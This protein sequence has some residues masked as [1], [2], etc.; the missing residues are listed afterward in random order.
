MERRVL[1]AEHF[2]LPIV[3]TE[4]DGIRRVNEPVT[5]GI[6]LSKGQLFNPAE[7]ALYNASN[8]RMPL[9][10]E[11]L[12]RWSDGSVQWV[13]LDF[14]ATVAPK[15]TVAYMLK[16]CIELASV[17][18]GAPIT[19]QE[20]STCITV[21]TGYALFFLNPMVCSPFERVIIQG[22]NVLDE[23]G[24]SIVLLDEEGRA[25]Q[26]CI[27]SYE[28]EIA[29]PLRTTLCLQG[30]FPGAAQ[31]SLA[32]FIARLS[33]YAG[34]G[35][36]EMRFTVHNP[37]AATHPDGLW[38]LGDTG[39]VYFRD[40]AF[41]LP[42]RA[43]N[44]VICMWTPQPPQPLVTSPETPLEIYQDSSGGQNWR[45]I[46]HTNR[47]GQVM[48]TFQGY[49]VT[50]DGNIIE[51]GKRATPI[52]ALGGH[53]TRVMAAVDKFWQ[54]FPKAMEADHNTLSIRLFPQQYRDVYELQG[55]E[56]KTH[57]V[58]LQFDRQHQ[59]I[60]DVSW[61][62]CRLQARTTPEWYVRSKA[63][64]YLTPRN[65][66][67]HADYQA[68]IDTAIEGNN[69]FFDRREIIDEYG[70][71][72]FGDLYADHEAVGHKGEAPLISHY[73]N[74][75]DVIYGA[76]IQYLR[77]GDVRWFHLMND[78][79]KHV[80]DI[81]IYHTSDDRPSYNGGMF[82]HTDH[83]VDA[84]TATHRTYSKANGAIN[85]GHLY[86]GGPSNEHNYTSGLLYYY[87]LTGEPLAREAV[88]S[89]AD[90]VINMD[91]GTRRLLGLFDR[92]PTGLA[93]STTNR[94]YHGPGRG[95]GNSINALLDAYLLTGY[96][97]YLSKAEELIRR[98]IHP[99]DEITKRELHDVEHRWSYT[100]FLQILGKYLDF[101][102]DRGE[103]DFMYGYA[104]ES[105][106]HY[107]RWMLEHEVP[108]TSILDRVEIPTE[109][110]PA[111]DIRKSNIFEFAA[112]HSDEP[113]RT[114]FF[115]KADVFFQ[116]CIR[117]LQSFETCT[118]TR[119][120]VL[121]M[122][123][124]FRHAYWQMHLDEWAPSPDKTYDFGEP[125]EFTPQL[126]GLYRAK[127]RFSEVMQTAK[128]GGRHLTRLLRTSL[129]RTAKIHG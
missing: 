26:P 113:L 33:F 97:K 10:N 114:S 70:W 51:E 59:H 57:T 36:V 9:Q 84:A 44:N 98:C 25:Y 107:A 75:Y 42:L 1:K 60:A 91:R 6:P 65:A 74:Q 56:Q 101:K 30:V 66:D 62:H 41:H 78:L 19:V 118:L 94:G 58:L 7:I 4:Y 27:R 85:G 39:S 13:L 76:L 68:L 15:A 50:A 116:T 53:E 87:F 72:H 64:S 67:E 12:A 46:N 106:L 24:S 31:Y 21:D 122:A 115:Q 111:Q 92:R 54:N 55:G 83:Y 23:H 63:I 43:Q 80:I 5:V 121:L 8:E 88:R 35:L 82:W 2:A 22:H 128:D 14:L 100:V 16:G 52:M 120:L 96:G 89:L 3:L 119:P 69:T 11:V 28:I 95:A 18:H 48:Q 109:T 73:N 32:R 34:S 102:I 117:D 112:K 125:E 79:A 47:Y 99:R 103:L 37:L 17:M 81:D 61:W 38:D 86:G 127:E 110:W 126:Y 104:R 93:S 105:L 45:S 129:E 29:G 20:T 123:N 108:Y 49:R 77:S 40:L 124:A 90:W 71:R